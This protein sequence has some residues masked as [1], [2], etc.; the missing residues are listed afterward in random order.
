MHA[1][2][3]PSGWQEPRKEGMM[4]DALGSMGPAGAVAGGALNAFGA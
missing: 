3:R 2:K 4:K 1:T